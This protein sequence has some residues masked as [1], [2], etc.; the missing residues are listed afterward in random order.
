MYIKLDMQQIRIIDT[1][2]KKS[3]LCCHDACFLQLRPHGMKWKK[4][5]KN[6][7]KVSQRI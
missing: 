6:M 3:Y 4:K 1:K 2:K 5:K 7:V